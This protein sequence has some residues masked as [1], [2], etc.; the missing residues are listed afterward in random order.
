MKGEAET[1][2]DGRTLEYVP[3]TQL[4]IHWNSLAYKPRGLLGAWL[5]LSRY[6]FSA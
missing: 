2:K 5:E 1:M 6:K 4:R 3:E